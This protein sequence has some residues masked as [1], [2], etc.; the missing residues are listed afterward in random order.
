MG[1]AKTTPKN[2]INGH[3]GKYD[4][5]EKQQRKK[6]AL[7]TYQDSF[8]KNTSVG[9]TKT[10]NTLPGFPQPFQEGSSPEIAEEINTAN[11]G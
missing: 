8:L 5:W 7:L 1:L 6:Y 11:L 3:T 9:V 10:T 4:M 2:G